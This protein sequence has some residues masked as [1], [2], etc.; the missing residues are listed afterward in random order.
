MTFAEKKDLINFGMFVDNTKPTDKSVE[1]LIGDINSAA[2]AD[3]YRKSNNKVKAIQALQ[4]KLT[5]VDKRLYSHEIL[6]TYIYFEDYEGAV[7]AATAFGFADEPTK[8]LLLFIFMHQKTHEKNIACG[9][10]I[11]TDVI[12]RT[13]EYLSKYFNI[14]VFE[15]FRKLLKDFCMN[16]PECKDK[17]CGLSVIA[18]FKEQCKDEYL[19]GLDS[20]C[21][22]YIYDEIKVSEALRVL[23]NR[24]PKIDEFYFKMLGKECSPSSSELSSI[25]RRVYSPSLFRLAEEMECLDDR[26]IELKDCYEKKAPGEV[27]FKSKNCKQARRIHDKYL[28]VLKTK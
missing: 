17:D 14:N 26:I 4:N 19:D 24:D 27:V 5:S 21:L 12:T 1:K 23:V 20:S 9:S 2:L 10:E 11:A 6:S 8:R 3:V 22:K 28:K 15:H 13:M 16:K 25:L 18:S 7:E